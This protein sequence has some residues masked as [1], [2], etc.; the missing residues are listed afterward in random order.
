M[1]CC[2]CV[3]CCM[4]VMIVW[5]LCIVLHLC[6]Y[7]VVVCSAKHSALQHGT[8]SQCVNM[9]VLFTLPLAASGAPLGDA[10]LPRSAPRRPCTGWHE[11]AA[12]LQAAAAGHSPRS[13]APVASIMSHHTHTHVMHHKHVMYPLHAHPHNVHITHVHT[14][15]PA[16]RHTT[17]IIKK[18]TKRHHHITHYDK[19]AC[20][21][22][23]I[24]DARP[25]PHLN[26][27]CSSCIPLFFP[28]QGPTQGGLPVGAPLP[29]SPVANPRGA[30]SGRLHH[31]EEL[32][33]QRLD[34]SM[35]AGPLQG[36]VGC[37]AV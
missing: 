10:A 2:V 22:P 23:C 24:I 13:P 37:C 35:A 36:G 19:A 31:R 16:H 18:P 4:C 33:P 25:S 17:L 30:A 21:S 28:R 27:L 20:T 8:C 15:T 6:N 3:L 11:L 9:R 14:H 34:R 7:C 29:P 12:G 32:H 1:V 5:R 26:P